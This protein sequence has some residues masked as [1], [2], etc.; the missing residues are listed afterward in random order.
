MAL[1]FDP[2]PFLILYII[3]KYEM[4][5]YEVMKYRGMCSYTVLTF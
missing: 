3:L 2:R 1:L 5:L 4:I